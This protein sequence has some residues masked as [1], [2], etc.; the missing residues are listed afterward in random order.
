MKTQPSRLDIDTS[1][2]AGL[3]VLSPDDSRKVWQAIDSLECFDPDQP[4]DSKIQKYTPPEM[5]TFYLLHASP[6][7]RVI[8]EITEE[9]EIKIIDLFRK[10]R[11]EAFAKF[12]N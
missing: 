8:F 5:R 7:Y 4:L 11:L 2:L 9:N 10:E 12:R 1:V 6:R 3:A